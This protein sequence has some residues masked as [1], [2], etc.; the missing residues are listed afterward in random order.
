MMEQPLTI[1]VNRIPPQQKTKLRIH[2]LPA[3]ARALTV[4]ML[5]VLRCPLDDLPAERQVRNPIRERDQTISRRRAYGTHPASTQQ[6]PR[7]RRQTCRAAT[8]HAYGDA[9]PRSSATP[10][11]Q[12][13]TRQGT[14]R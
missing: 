9:R 8:P 12:R 10:Q 7:P 5:K 1:L 13:T 14:A 3:L 11:R 4:R 6:R 2:E